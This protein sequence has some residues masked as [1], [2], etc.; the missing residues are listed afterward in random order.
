V[1]PGAAAA[2]C[3]PSSAGMTAA[4]VTVAGSSGAAYDIVL[5]GEGT[6]A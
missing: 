2:Q 4:G 1:A 3:D 6:V 5:V